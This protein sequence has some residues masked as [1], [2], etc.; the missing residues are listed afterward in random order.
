[1]I[2]I[3]SAARR[4][5]AKVRKGLDPSEVATHLRDLID[6]IR[7]ARSDEQEAV[8]KAEHLQRQLDNRN[9][10]DPATLSRVLGDE[11]V[12]VI[13]AARSAAEEIRGKAQE[14]AERLV[15]DAQLEASEL[16]ASATA[17][18][19]AAEREMAELREST[20]K[21]TESM[22]S[23]A[24]AEVA[25]LREESA[26]EVAE[27]ERSS[28]AE[29]LRLQEQAAQEIAALRD[30]AEQQSTEKLAAAETVLAEQTALAEAESER[31][32][33]L[34]TQT[35]DEARLDAE[36]ARQSAAL[37]AAQHVAA[38]ER[39]SAA[40]LSNA[41]LHADAQIE[42][43]R[44]RGREMVKEA[45]DTRDSILSDCASKRHLA[46]Q[47][48]EALRAGR[49]SLAESMATA[50]EFFDGVLAELDL[51]V[52]AARTAAADAA[53]NLIET[54]DA[55]LAELRA[56]MGVEDS[57]DEST[58]AGM[59]EDSPAVESS[60]AELPVEVS[61]DL[62]ELGR[63]P[64][65]DGSTSEPEQVATGKLR[66][67][68]LPGG[69]GDNPSQAERSASVG[70]TGDQVLDA[71]GRFEHHDGD[72]DDDLDDDF[73]DEFDDD[74]D[75][76]DEFD[77]DF[78]EEVGEL[79]EEPRRTG[80]QRTSPRPNL[81]PVST[82]RSR[83]TI[84]V[85]SEVDGNTNSTAARIGIAG[86][87]ASGNGGD[88]QTATNATSQT[89]DEAHPSVE[90]LFARLRETSESSDLPAAGSELHEESSSG[91]RPTSHGDPSGDAVRSQRGIVIDLVAMQPSSGAPAL[92]ALAEEPGTEAEE[93][94]SESDL[95]D[96]RD[97]LMAPIEREI[98]RRAKRMLADAENEILDRVRR[99]RKSSSPAALLGEIEEHSNVLAA[100]LRAQIREAQQAG[101]SFAGTPLGELAEASGVEEL[102]RLEVEWMILPLYPRLSRVIDRNEDHSEGRPELVSQLRGA[103]REWRTEKISG[104]A[105]DL[106]TRS[107]NLGVMGSLGPSRSVCWVVDQGG[108]PCADGEDNH[109]A[110]MLLVGEEFPTGHVCPPAH[111]GCRCVLVG[112]DQ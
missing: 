79:S 57:L 77:D 42:A 25:Q 15:R 100:A 28:K 66:L 62:E 2:D 24:E 29:R 11:T 41:I 76:D 45:R 89:P 108:L 47:Q 67:V 94:T 17:T 65:S 69:G 8:A 32:V 10:V 105:G 5:F 110:G 50:R 92:E 104:L 72:N 63:A 56:T 78:D 43:A 55:D 12:R 22:R 54:P 112:S 39:D 9:S 70:Q 53:Q 91:G 35:L 33:S 31:I 20:R 7:R 97:S 80:T 58:A 46:R 88:D 75:D 86:S 14:N 44:A 73:D 102:E 48:L 107:F 36:E 18:R 83:E 40:I 111:P 23:E 82:G 37:Q 1:M 109:L 4:E 103:F 106:A 51:A 90:A 38:A 52:P 98:L 93:G 74:F 71:A 64:G 95:L 6:E 84:N 99:Q 68:S 96:L 26:A 19:D 34:A 27:L 61:P 85:V 13:D 49:D 87:T 16:V 60:V 101:A 81:S 21:A 59:T 3:D 30:S